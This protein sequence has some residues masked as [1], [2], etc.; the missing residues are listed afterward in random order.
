MEGTFQT[1][2]APTNAIIS[3]TSHIQHAVT[4]LKYYSVY[5]LSNICTTILLNKI[6]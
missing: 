5:L 3:K 6:T 1:F 2:E 4:G